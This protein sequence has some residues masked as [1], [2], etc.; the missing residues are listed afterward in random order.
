MATWVRYCTHLALHVR[1]G[2]HGRTLASP[3]RRSNAGRRSHFAP[4]RRHERALRLVPH[5]DGDA[6]DVEAVGQES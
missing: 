2:I 5:V 3:E 6:G 1:R 4:E